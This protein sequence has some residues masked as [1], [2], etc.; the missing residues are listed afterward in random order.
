[1]HV[2]HII[3]KHW[4]NHDSQAEKLYC[5]S[6]ENLIYLSLADHIKAHELLYEIYKRPQD[7]GAVLMLQGDKKES[8][9]IWRQLGA[10]A[11]NEKLKNEGSNFWNSE[12]QTEMAS[13]SLARPDAKEIRS[14]G[15][16]QGGRIRNLNRAIKANDRYLFYYNNEPVLCIFNCETGG[17]VLKTLHE[18]KK[19]PLQRATPLLN[20]SRKTLNGWSCEKLVR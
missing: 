20:G 11:V 2:H 8:R 12:F 5:E 18:F 16:Q 4:F 15:G 6:E 9:L 3:P 10:K 1:M 19:T 17:D 13:R 7:K 14:K